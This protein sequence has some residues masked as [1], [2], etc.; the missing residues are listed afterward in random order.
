MMLEFQFFIAGHNV[1]VLHICCGFCCF[2][3]LLVLD[4]T[5]W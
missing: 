5:T 3:L 1:S 2:M 4:L